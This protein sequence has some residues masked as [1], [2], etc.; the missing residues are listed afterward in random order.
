MPRDYPYLNASRS[1]DRRQKDE[2]RRIVQ[3]TSNFTAGLPGHML[4]EAKTWYPSAHEE[5]V[6]G[7]RD[8]NIGTHRA[9]GIIAALSS[10]S[11]WD[12]ANRGILGE[13]SKLNESDW[14]MI[15]KASKLPRVQLESG[16]TT[17]AKRPQEVSDMLS[18]RSKTLSQ[19]TVSQLMQT[20][21]LLTVNDS[22]YEDI[23]SRAGN[24]KR[25]AFASNIE[26]VDK[27]PYVTIDYHIADLLANTMRGTKQKRGLDQ[28]MSR[29]A[30]HEDMMRQS[31]AAHRAMTG[32]KMS[33]I[34]YQALSWLGAKA[35]ERPVNPETGKPRGVG[36]PRTGQRYF[37]AKGVPDENLSNYPRR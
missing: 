6:Q 34:D 30:A 15:E 10:G 14:G 35:V 36:V 12:S 27:S 4:E 20:R 9:A 31:A 8:L 17:G 21:R 33:D 26:H 5:A 13:V 24:P 1:G 22:T 7:G 25:N 32:Q 11:D 16:R 28:S 3:R 37:N 2:F 18:E 29:Y 19:S 23:L